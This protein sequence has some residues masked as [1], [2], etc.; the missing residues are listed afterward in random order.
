MKNFEF[1]GKFIK[2]IVVAWIVLSQ[3]CLARRQITDS[4]AGKSQLAEIK[5]NLPSANELEKSFGPRCQDLKFDALLMNRSPSNDKCQVAMG[6][7]RQI[8]VKISGA[9]CD[10]K[11]I[12]ETL[13]FDGPRLDSKLQ[14]G[15]TYSVLLEAGNINAEE[16][17]FSNVE[18]SIRNLSISPGAPEMIVFQAV[19]FATE[20]GQKLGFPSDSG[21]VP[22]SSSDIAIEAE[23]AK[24]QKPRSKSATDSAQPKSDARSGLARPNFSE[25]N[26][27]LERKCVPCHALGGRNTHFVNNEKNFASKPEEKIAFVEDDMMPP[28]N[29]GLFLS[30]AEKETIIQFWRT[31]R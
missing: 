9:T 28:P 11:N 27:V 20:L 17:Y 10:M 4:M 24:S 1:L 26:K 19:L 21:I 13:D 30:R 5:L 2:P 12:V 16:V 25:V 7:L 22:D 31:S 6:M 8:R 15:C 23:F 29:S 18:S 14:K 3:S